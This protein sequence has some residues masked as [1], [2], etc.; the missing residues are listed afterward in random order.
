MRKYN[1]NYGDIVYPPK[2]YIRY[3]GE[4]EGTSRTKK[5]RLYLYDIERDEHFS[6]ALHNA[7]RG[8]VETPSRRKEYNQKHAIEN[9]KK[10]LKYF[11]GDIMGPNKDIIFCRRI[12]ALYS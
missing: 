1:F 10:T 8:R 5:R 4:I 3:E 6:A 9:S 12:I 7:V 11:V 2:P